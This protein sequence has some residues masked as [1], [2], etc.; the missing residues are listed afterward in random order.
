MGS[1]HVGANSVT[2]VTAYVILYSYTQ[3]HKLV[4]IKS[5]YEIIREKYMY[6]TY[7]VHLVGINRRNWLQERSEL[8]TSQQSKRWGSV[9][10]D[11]QRGINYPLA[12]SCKK[13]ILPS[14]HIHTDSLPSSSQ[15]PPS[16]GPLNPTLHR[17]R[18]AGS[19]LH[20]RTDKNMEHSGCAGYYGCKQACNKIISSNTRICMGQAA[21]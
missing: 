7:Y 4:Q 2:S 19:A 20:S 3:V 12:E 16:R 14:A 1:K 11:Q 17:S 10:R 6:L 13:R 15:M 21:I 9:A 5:I 8:K 18:D